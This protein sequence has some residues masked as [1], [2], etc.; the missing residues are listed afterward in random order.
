MGWAL[1]ARAG[2]VLRSTLARARLQATSSTAWPENVV[3]PASIHTGTALTPRSRV[4]SSVTCASDH[5]AASPGPTAGHTRDRGERRLVRRAPPVAP[6]ARRV[7][8]EPPGRRP[9]RAA[10]PEPR[11]RDLPVVSVHPAPHSASEARRAPAP[12]PRR[13]PPASG[14]SRSSRHPPADPSRRRSPLP[15]PPS[16]P[17]PRQRSGAPPFRTHTRTHDLRRVPRTLPQR[18]I[19]LI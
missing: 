18:D 14:T 16:R 7:R 11:R 10:R 4:P 15:W 9:R 19:H 2:G 12:G 8:P 13:R 17:G 1:A 3:R 6:V 5:S